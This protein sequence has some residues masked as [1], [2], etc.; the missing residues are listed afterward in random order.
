MDLLFFFS[1]QYF[2]TDSFN[3]FCSLTRRVFCKPEFK[4]PPCKVP[5]LG[6]KITPIQYDF[7]SLTSK[8]EKS[9]KWKHSG[10]YHYYL[11]RREKFREERKEVLPSILTKIQ[12]LLFSY[13]L[14]LLHHQKTRSRCHRFQK[15]S[16]CSI[17]ILRLSDLYCGI[18]L[19]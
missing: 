8:S 16:L 5:Y 15:T 11:G 13:L 7:I 9:P 18:L 3:Y 10:C 12:R 2:K 6:C 19:T 4:K 1:R 14:R 17:F